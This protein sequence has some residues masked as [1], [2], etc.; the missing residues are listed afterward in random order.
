MEG[1]MRAQVF[2]EAEVMKLEMIDI[3]KI[4]DNEGKGMCE[5]KTYLKFLKSVIN[6]E[7]K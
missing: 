7:N 2:Y 5:N 3:P 6:K 1:K 4:S